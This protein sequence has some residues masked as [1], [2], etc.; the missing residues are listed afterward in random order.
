MKAKLGLVLGSGAARGWAHI[1]ALRALEEAGVVPDV[2]CGCSIG[3]FVGSAA[4]A[5][6]PADVQVS[7]RL[8]HLGLMDYHR[9]GEAIAEGRAAVKRMLPAIEHALESP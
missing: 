5:G 9:A 8:A 4:A 6:E 3:A 1:G 7:P 2:I